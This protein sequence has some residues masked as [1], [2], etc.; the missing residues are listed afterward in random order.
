MKKRRQILMLICLS[1]IVLLTTI[2]VTTYR[3]TITQAYLRK[4][5]PSAVQLQN[6]LILNQLGLAYSSME[7]GNFAAA[8]RSLKKILKERPTNSMAMQLLGHV[9]Y[10]T[11]RY[12]E[13]EQ[14]YRNML[15]NNEFDATAYNNLGQTLNRQGRQ[16]EALQALLQSRELNPNNMTV[17]INLSVVYAALNEHEKA[18]EMFMT[19]HRQLLEKQRETTNLKGDRHE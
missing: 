13:A 7:K 6:E 8:E 9:Y 10:R 12:K 11:E 3:P 5:S 14:V 17:Y 18:R 4:N 2:L 15:K 1:T 19:A 16:Q